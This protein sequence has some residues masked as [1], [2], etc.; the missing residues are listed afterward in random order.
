MNL[1]KS[2]EAKNINLVYFLP[3]SPLFFFLH[4][5]IDF[6]IKA[7]CLLLLCTIYIIVALFMNSVFIASIAL[8]WKKVMNQ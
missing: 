7:I 8:S 3:F 2:F 5:A 1:T 6:F 4:L